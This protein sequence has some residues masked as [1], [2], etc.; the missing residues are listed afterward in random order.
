MYFNYLEMFTRSN[1]I[2]STCSVL[3]LF[4]MT[5]KRAHSEEDFEQENVLGLCYKVKYNHSMSNLLF[6][7][8]IM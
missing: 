7:I 3:F 5:D 6:F 1:L 8:V 2:K 4:M